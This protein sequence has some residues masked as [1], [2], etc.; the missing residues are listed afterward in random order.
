MTVKE[1]IELLST[2]SEDL[3]VCVDGYEDGYEDLTPE[4]VQQ[5]SI[6]L[7]INDGWWNGPHGVSIDPDA[8]QACVL[9]RH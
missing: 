5:I 4:K 8:I 2:Y 1:L 9:T 6:K 7:N 3:R